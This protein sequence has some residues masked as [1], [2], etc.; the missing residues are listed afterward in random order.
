MNGFPEFDLSGQVALVTGAARGLG[1]AI[2]LALANAGADVALGLRDRKTGSGLVGEIE[3]MGRR[4][5]RLQMDMAHLDQISSAVEEAVAHFGRLDILVNNAGVSPGNPAEDFTEEDFDYTI[6]VNV[7]GTFFASQSAGRVM[8]RQKH[9]RIINM[10][11]QAGFVALPTESV[12]CTTKAAIAHLTKCLAVEW[13]KHNITVNA[14]APT[15]IFTPG[16]EEALADPGFRADTVE[17][18]AA[19]HRIGEPMEVTGAVVFLASPAASL[20]TGHT[21][22]IDGGWTAR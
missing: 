18:I 9:G 14:V 17:R 12:Y 2:S 7:K 20:I 5:L 21:I 3:A 13:G 6:A 16:T 22:L 11:S 4:V 1:R 15:F 8:I 10:S 19:L